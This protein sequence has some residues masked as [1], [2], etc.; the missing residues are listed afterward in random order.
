[1]VKLVKVDT[2]SYFI[3][4]VK[5]I[6]NIVDYNTKFINGNTENGIL[7][8]CPIDED[9]DMVRDLLNDMNYIDFIPIDFQYGYPY[10]RGYISGIVSNHLYEKMDDF[11]GD[12]QIDLMLSKVDHGAVTMNHTGPAIE[13]CEGIT[14]RASA[15]EFIK[16]HFKPLVPSEVYID[17]VMNYTSFTIIDPIWERET[18]IFEKTTNI[19][20]KI[21][22]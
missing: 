22:K 1:M 3:N 5:T 14:G 7:R 17:L 9:Y 18:Y 11:I 15:F 21:R 6:D 16:T 2:K 19:I 12:N 4:N 10:S 20:E 13:A 8:W